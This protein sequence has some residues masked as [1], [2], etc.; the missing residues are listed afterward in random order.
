MKIKNQKR[1]GS[2]LTF[3]IGL[4]WC[5]SLGISTANAGEDYQNFM[6]VYEAHEKEN[7]L[8]GMS[9][10]LGGGI[11]FVTSAAL[12]IVS[13]QVLPMIGYNLTQ[14]LSSSAVAYGANLY[15]VG[16]SFTIEAERLKA[17]AEHIRTNVFLTPI[18][19]QKLLDAEVDSTVTR[20]KN[21][22]IKRH[23]IR[24][25]LRLASAGTSVASL[26]FSRTNST[27]GTM[28]SLFLVVL[29]AAGGAADLFYKPSPRE[30]DGVTLGLS[31]NENLGSA[32]TLSYHW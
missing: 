10:M 11:G 14:L 9:F 26:V 16:D 28:T 31:L 20:W 3:I 13:T 27:A 12:S 5:L 2:A 1:V 32:V 17:T 22:S 8:N 21:Q 15:F 18:E 6:S 23:K 25:Y 4:S 24:G 29:A 7:K 19:K 30:Y